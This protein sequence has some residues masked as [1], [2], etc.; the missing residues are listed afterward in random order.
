MNET[1]SKEHLWAGDVL[2]PV[3]LLDPHLLIL[4][5]RSEDLTPLDQP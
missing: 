5:R 2:H 1:K 4:L 3:V